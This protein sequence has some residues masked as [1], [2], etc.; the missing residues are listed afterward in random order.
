MRTNLLVKAFWKNVEK[1][2][3]KRKAAQSAPD[4]DDALLDIDYAGDGRPMHTLNI[5]RPKG[6]KGLLPVILDVHGGGWYYGDKELNEYFCRSL[7]G[8]GFAVADM[9]YILAPEADVFAQVKDVFRAMSFLKSH[10][11]EFGLDMDK[12]FLV[13]DSA[14]GHLVGLAI[15]IA[16]S[17]DLRR[18]FDVQPEADVKAAGLIC[19]AA[20]PLDMFSLPKWMMKFYFNP[21]LGKGYLKNGV[22]ELCSFTKILQKDVCPCFVVSSYADMLKKSSVAAYEALIAQGTKAELFLLEQPMVEGHELEHVFN[23]LYWDWEESMAANSAM[24]DF[25]KGVLTDS[26]E[27]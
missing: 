15:N 12:F 9:S 27:S 20:D 11:E 16:K 7:V 18:R 2:D 13:G 5:Y 23:V 21:I 26:P 14:G 1:K 3:A 8:Y 19:P 17:E 6:Q 22:A 4:F 10:A 25:F 24:C